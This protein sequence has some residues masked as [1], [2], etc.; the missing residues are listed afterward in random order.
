MESDPGEFIGSE[1]PICFSVSGIDGLYCVR[2]ERCEMPKSRLERLR[3]IAP[4]RPICKG[5]IEIFSM[6]VRIWMEGGSLEGA[7]GP[8]DL[9][10]YVG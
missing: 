6:I 9:I 1:R 3:E 8:F 7:R 5:G 4:G 10:P 2:S